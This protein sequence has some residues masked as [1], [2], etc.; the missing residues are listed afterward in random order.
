MLL[1]VV[2]PTTILSSLSPNST[3]TPGFLSI[4]T[5]ARTTTALGF[6]RFDYNSRETLR[7][8]LWGTRGSCYPRRQWGS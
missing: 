7:R 6:G 4:S 1:G 3:L 8:L 2:A 5:W